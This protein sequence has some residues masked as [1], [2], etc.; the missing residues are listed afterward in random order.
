MKALSTK[1][2]WAWAILNGKPVENRNWYTSFRGPFL[3]HASKT[4]DREGY[5]WIYRN[6][7]E[8]GIHERTLPTP[9]QFELGGIVGQSNLVACVKDMGSPWFFG[10][11]GF[12]LKDSLAV[13]FHPCKGQLGFF[14]VE[15]PPRTRQ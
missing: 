4:F 6:R 7:K 12:V 5:E 3:L 10:P 14:D 13:P 9:D 1:Q 2:P 15:W 8:L 11:W